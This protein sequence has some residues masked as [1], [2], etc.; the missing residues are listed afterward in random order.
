MIE[1]QPPDTESGARAIKE[2]LEA[3][4]TPCLILLRHGRTEWNAH[5]RL[6]GQRD[7][8]LDSLGIGQARALG[9]L[10]GQIPL[11]QVLCS[12]LGR[13]T[14][15]ARAV[16]ERNVLIPEIVATPLLREMALGLLEGPR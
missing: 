13:C 6:Q 15:T 14:R 1:P 5:G 4:T 11:S 9:T 7:S 2:F 10:L 3:K 8:P 12:D 16:A